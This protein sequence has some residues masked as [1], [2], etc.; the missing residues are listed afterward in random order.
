MHAGCPRQVVGDVDRTMARSDAMM[1]EYV[2]VRDGGTNLGFCT[3]AEGFILNPEQAKAKRV[4]RWCD[5][6]D[7]LPSSSLI[8]F[9]S[10]PCFSSS[11][12]YSWD[13]LLGPPILYITSSGGSAGRID[14]YTS[15]QDDFRRIP[16]HPIGRARDGARFD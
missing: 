12:S 1:L 11:L 4:C 5:G 8:H 15:H 2:S 13:S 9:Y 14:H 10:L 7:S 6:F 3:D 16:S